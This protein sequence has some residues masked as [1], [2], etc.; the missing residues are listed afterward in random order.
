MRMQTETQTRRERWLIMSEKLLTRTRKL[1][2]EGNVR[3]IIVVQNGKTIAE[4]PLIAGVAG[5]V[6]AP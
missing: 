1:L 6:L 3:R 5:I 2:Q 4:F